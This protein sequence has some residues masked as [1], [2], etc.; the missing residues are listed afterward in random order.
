MK[1]RSSRVYDTPFATVSKERS[2][3]TDRRISISLTMAENSSLESR[4]QGYIAALNERPFPGLAKHMNPTV[5]LNSASMDLSEFEQILSADIN[6]A[7]DM[8]FKLHIL[9]AD[10]GKQQVG[11]RI[12]FT[13]T[14]I[15]DG[16][17]MDRKVRKGGTF[18]CM[19][20]LFYQYREGKIAEV[21]HL[22]GEFVEIGEV[23]EVNG[24]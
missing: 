4:F 12:E 10:E 22:P 11:C 1:I 6:A 2:Q 19:E 9:L 15:S 24:S 7:P 21:W 8:H 23:R 17:L 16:E 3:S 18:S 14:P 20:H 13:C 5:N